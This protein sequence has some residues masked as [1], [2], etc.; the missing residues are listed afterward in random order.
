M[1]TARQLDALKEV[2]HSASA[3]AANALSRML[4]P[5]TVWV[6]VPVVLQLGR[7]QSSLL[8]GGADEPVFAVT[9]DFEGEIE[10]QL[11]WLLPSADAGRLGER[12]RHRHSERI[13]WRSGLVEAANV[14]AS[15]QL[16]AL[17]TALSTPL[18]PSTPTVLEAP[19]GQVFPAS[20]EEPSSTVAFSRFTAGDLPHYGGWLLLVL[21]QNQC[22]S[23]LDRL[24]KV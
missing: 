21:D 7:S 20:P 22:Y 3:Q 5:A 13:D 8:I 18:L 17:G 9:F 12:L 24:G 10:G 23:T 6:D 14:V 2:S 19:L 11:W 4:A 1:L 15:A 16:S